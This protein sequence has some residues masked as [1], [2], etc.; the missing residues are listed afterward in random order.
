[1][2]ALEPMLATIVIYMSLAYGIMYLLVSPSL[3][4]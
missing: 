2:L 1:M 3:A 4:A